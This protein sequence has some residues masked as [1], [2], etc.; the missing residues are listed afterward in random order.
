MFRSKVYKK[1]HSIRVLVV[2]FNIVL[3]ETQVQLWNYGNL[4]MIPDFLPAKGTGFF[5]ESGDD[6]GQTG[7]ETTE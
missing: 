1:D 6:D 4:E 3:I 7:A 5:I 2:S